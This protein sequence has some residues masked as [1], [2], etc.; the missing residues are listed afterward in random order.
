MT[1]KVFLEVP[2]GLSR[3]MKRVSE[4]LTTFAPPSV[5]VVSDPEK[6]DLVLLHTIGFPE[7]ED[8]IARLTREGRAIAIAQ[9][10]LRSTQRPNTRDWLP[11]WRQALVVWSYYDLDA[12]LAEDGVPVNLPNFYMSPLG[13]DARVFQAEP[14]LDARYFTMLTSGYVAE[15][16][17][18]QECA[19]AV[20]RVR[21]QLFHLGP[22]IVRGD[23]VTCAM[24]MDDLTL[25]RVYRSCRF[26]A[27]LR[28][29]EGFEMPAVEGLLCGARPIMFDR[30]HYREWFDGLAEFVPEGSKEELTDALVETFLRGARPVSSTERG[31]VAARFDWSRIATGFWRSVGAL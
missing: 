2:H 22:D 1:L 23:H 10:C 4:A 26:V 16:E 12:A 5:T 9:Y 30:P 25:A 7:T 6:A 24:G 8:A 13:C 31:E 3:A 17:G 28:R 20:E 18:V 21:G 11:L 14:R 19:D 29:C 27:G 15:S